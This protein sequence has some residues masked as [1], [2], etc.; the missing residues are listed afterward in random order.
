MA[1]LAL[2]VIRVTD[3]LEIRGFFLLRGRVLLRL[4][5]LASPEPYEGPFL[6]VVG[7]ERF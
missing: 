5:I 3:R 7:G 1:I 4:T 2:L 6:Y